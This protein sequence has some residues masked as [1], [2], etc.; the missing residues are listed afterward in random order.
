M[1]NK[2]TRAISA[3]LLLAAAATAGS[4]AGSLPSTA[5]AAVAPMCSEL[6]SPSRAGHCAND[7]HCLQFNVNDRTSGRHFRSLVARPRESNSAG[8]ISA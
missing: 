5:N 6:A 2:I 7:P 4:T 1:S 3:A 8:V